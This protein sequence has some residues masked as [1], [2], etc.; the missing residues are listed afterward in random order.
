VIGAAR[1]LA[2][3]T[4]LPSR[5]LEAGERTF[6]PRTPI[7]HAMALAQHAVYCETLRAL[8]CEV[9]TL[10][11]NADLPDA[12][13]VEDT[14][15]VLDEVAVLALPGAP[16][17]RGEVPGVAAALARHRPLAR[18]S[19]PGTLDGGDVVRVGRT[20]LVGASRRTNADG[21]RELSEIGRAHGYAVRVVPIRDCLHLK[22]ACCALP[23]DRLLVNTRF[24][25]TDALGGFDLVHVPSDEPHA[26]DV[27]SVGNSVILS[28]SHPRTADLISRLSFEVHALA[29]SEFEKAEGGVTCLSL[30]FPR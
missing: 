22:S 29:V 14:A 30:V 16:S 28:A 6:A 20:L 12:V 8:G 13:F 17:R 3:V 19:L 24:L 10:D 15:V 1:S 26:A 11:V 18:I 2:A 27:L 25:A 5:S 4:H 7:D 23:D 21:A 9:I